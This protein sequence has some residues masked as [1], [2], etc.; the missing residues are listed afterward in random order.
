MSPSGRMQHTQKS[1]L[2][3]ASSADSCSAGRGTEAE[4]GGNEWMGIV[5]SRDIFGMG[6]QQ[7]QSCRSFS[8]QQACFGNSWQGTGT[9][10]GQV[11]IERR[12][13]S[14]AMAV[15]HIGLGGWKGAWKKSFTELLVSTCTVIR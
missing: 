13:V 14:S 10:K 11:D 12:A 2:V 9:S 4:R 3:M 7:A 5:E 1:G 15:G 8:H 6:M